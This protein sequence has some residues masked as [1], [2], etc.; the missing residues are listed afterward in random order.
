[1]VYTTVL[2]TS[3]PTSYTRRLGEFNI[4]CTYAPTGDGGDQLV[5]CRAVVTVASAP[6]M[7]KTQPLSTMVGSFRATVDDS[8]S[9]DLSSLVAPIAVRT[10]GSWPEEDAVK[11]YSLPI[12]PTTGQIYFDIEYFKNGWNPASTK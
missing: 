1:M 6:R 2:R 9:S 8:S 12:E 4:A 3:P 10:T 11:G 5:S 7:A